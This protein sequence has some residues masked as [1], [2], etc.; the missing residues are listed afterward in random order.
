[1]PQPRNKYKY[2]SRIV[3]ELVIFYAKQAEHLAA[4]RACSAQNCFN[5]M[6][7]AIVRQC[8]PKLG[9]RQ[10]FAVEY[11]FGHSAAHATG[12]F[13]GDFITCGMV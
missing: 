2:D 4:V 1:M 6:R 13:N 10:F 7:G 3:K 5:F 9:I 8:K 11:Q 12:V